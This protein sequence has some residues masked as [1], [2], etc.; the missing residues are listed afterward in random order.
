M[1]CMS[2]LN[3]QMWFLF[4]YTRERPQEMHTKVL[5]GKGS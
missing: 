1:D 5:S 3:V 2:N 4:V